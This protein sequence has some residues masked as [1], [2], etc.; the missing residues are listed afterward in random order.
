MSSTQYLAWAEIN[1]PMLKHKK[2]RE[3]AV[4]AFNHCDEIIN[5]QE[6]EI[7]RLQQQND[8]LLSE[9]HDA[10]HREKIF[11]AENLELKLAVADAI[12]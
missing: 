6:Q 12:R 9:L 2:S 4:S 3:V 10:E 11:M 7:I 1:Q 5:S 8:L